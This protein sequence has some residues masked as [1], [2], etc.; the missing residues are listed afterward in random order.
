MSASARSGRPRSSSRETIAEAAS[1]LFLEQGYVET[2]ITDITRRAGVGRSSFF[3][4]FSS[5]ADV[6]W[7]GF[8]ARLAVAE[9]GVDDDA[10]PVRDALAAVAD[11]L[12]PDS[13]ALAITNAHAMGLADELERDRAVR[14]A[15]LQRAVA[16]RLR[17]EGA[18]DLAAQV[19]AAA[20]A[21]AVLAAVWTW[22]DRTT[23]D[24]ALA[25]VLG[26]ALDL[27]AR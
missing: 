27:A 5:K 20:Y 25:D 24:A 7:S 19:R 2:S 21:A 16:A 15:R 3:N 8:D 14:Q 23:E 13:L 9:A 22:A 26:P 10:V 11:D 18:S 1:E 6:L 4:Y 12:A 17:R